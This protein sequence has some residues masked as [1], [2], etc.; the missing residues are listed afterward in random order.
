MDIKFEMGKLT[1]PR[2]KYIHMQ[3]CKN[4]LRIIIITMREVG[5]E[6]KHETNSKS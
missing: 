2:W 6:N 3:K 4:T 5:N 1:S